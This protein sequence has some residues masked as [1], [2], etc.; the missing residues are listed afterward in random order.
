MLGELNAGANCL[1]LAYCASRLWFPAPLLVVAP[2]TYW[3]IGTPALSTDAFC[4]EAVP[5]W[6]CVVAD[7]Y[8]GAW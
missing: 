4:D 7:N 8:A 2:R 3:V 6:Y 5:L 1:L